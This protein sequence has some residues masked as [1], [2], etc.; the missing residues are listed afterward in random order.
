M[1]ECIRGR[2]QTGPCIATFHRFVHPPLF[3]PSNRWRNL[4]PHNRIGYV[5]LI[6]ISLG[7]FHKRDYSLIP[8]WWGVLSGDSVL[9][10]VVSSTVTCFC[11]ILIVPLPVWVLLRIP[12]ILMVSVC[13]VPDSLLGNS[14]WNAASWFRSYQRTLRSQFCQLIGNFITFNTL[15]TWHPYQ[16]SSVML[17]QLREGLMTVPD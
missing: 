13:P 7:T 12:N 14:C 11:L 5:Q 16:L 4:R 6:H 17:N 3:Q 1:N 10:V 15:V 9:W 8:I 2:P